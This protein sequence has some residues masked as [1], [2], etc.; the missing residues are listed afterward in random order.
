MGVTIRTRR[1][2]KRKDTRMGKHRPEAGKANHD[3][4]ATNGNTAG[5]GLPIE[6]LHEN[7]GSYVGIRALMASPEFGAAESPLTI[8]LGKDIHGHAA[9]ADLARLSHILIAGL[10]GSGTNQCVISMLVS[11]LYKSPPDAVKM[12]VIDPKVI[13]LGQLNGA[14]HLLAPVINDPLKAVGAL[15]WAVKEME[16]R[17]QILADCQKEDFSG[18][19]RLAAESGGEYASMARWVIVVGELADRMLYARNDTEN[20]IGHLTEKA[21]IV[22]MHLLVATRCPSP[23]VLTDAVK[24]S[25]PARIAFAVSSQDNSRLILGMPGAEK[26][27]GRSDMLFS[28]LSGAGPDRI[29]GCFVSDREEEQVTA[30]VRKN[31]AASYEQDILDEMERYRDAREKH[32]AADAG[33]DDE[34]VCAA[35]ACAL[36][37]GYIS[38]SM[39]QRRLR[40]SYSR[41]GRLVDRMEEL[42]IVGPADG[43]KPR[44]VLITARQWED[45]KSAGVDENEPGGRR[46]V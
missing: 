42:G 13:V 17:Y 40:Y 44:K 28:P 2:E 11:L 41:A 30:F 9:I 19:N 10:R 1:G 26:L 4:I 14:P 29:Q 34:L 36:E 3:P 32:G 22:G 20:A 46:W 35:I 33:I 25:I 24:E 18:Y 21:H 39:L 27:P 8:A 16:R 23:E 15:R 7:S 45:M 5:I 43:S 37:V 6:L 38:I 12:L 31:S